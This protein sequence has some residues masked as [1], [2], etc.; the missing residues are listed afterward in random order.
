MGSE[1]QVVKWDGSQLKDLEI[2]F[3]SA[4]SAGIT[5]NSSWDALQLDYRTNV[6]LFLV[7]ID[8]KIAG[9]SYAHQIDDWT[10]S[11]PENYKDTYRVFARTCVLPEFRQFK[12]HFPRGSLAQASGITAY[13]LKLQW[14][15]AISSGAKNIIWTTNLVGD[16]HSMKMT[17]Y[18]KKFSSYNTKYYSFL[19]NKYIYGTEQV[20]WKLLT[21]DII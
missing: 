4:E 9:M 20:V 17:N 2:F 19:E 10:I 12:L 11:D 15:H 14:D 7:Y 21:G 13:T 1:L 16:I 6:A 18:L 5:N 3:K 8:N